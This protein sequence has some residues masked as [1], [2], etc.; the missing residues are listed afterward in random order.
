MLHDSQRITQGVKAGSYF[1]CEGLG[2]V[3]LKLADSKRELNLQNVDYAP[4]C[5]ANLLSVSALIAETGYIVVFADH[6]VWIFDTERDLVTE[7][8]LCNGSYYLDIAP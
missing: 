1:R 4:D 6:R 5:N 7:G 2:K 8:I 3:D